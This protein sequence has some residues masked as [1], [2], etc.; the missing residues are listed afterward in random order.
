MMAALE[1]PGL[2]WT[3]KVRNFTGY[4]LPDSHRYYFQNG[5]ILNDLPKL[6]GQEFASTNSMWFNVTRWIIQ[7]PILSWF[8]YVH[9]VWLIIDLLALAVIILITFQRHDDCLRL[10]W[11]V[12]FVP[13]AYYGSYLLAITSSEFRFMF[14]SMLITQV[15][16]LTLTFSLMLNSR[17]RLQ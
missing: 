17:N 2:L 5:I 6:P 1:H 13:T 16:V 4:I 3:V 8:S 9:I 11:K 7:N 12:L 15:I 10:L 14:P